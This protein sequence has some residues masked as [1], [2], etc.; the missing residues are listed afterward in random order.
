MEGLI[1][2]GLGHGDEIAEALGD[3][4]PFLMDDPQGGIAVL[5]GVGDDPEGEEIVDLAEIDLLSLHLREML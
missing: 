5:D 1:E 4:G 2:I 3:G